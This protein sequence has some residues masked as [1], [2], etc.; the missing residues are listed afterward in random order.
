V[1]KSNR[2]NSARENVLQIILDNMDQGIL[3]VD[4]K[5]RVVMFN[6]RLL[7]LFDYMVEDIAEDMP[8][9]EVLRRWVARG[10]HDEATMRQTIEQAHSREP[11]SIEIP[12]PDGRW[13]EIRHTP[14]PEGGLVRTFT[15][16]TERKRAQERLLHLAHHDPLTDLPN[17]TLFHDRL[18]HAI[19]VATRAEDCLAILYLDLDG[20]KA[21]NDR[22]GHQSGDLLLQSIAKRLRGSVRKSDTVSRIGGDE[23]IVLLAGACSDSSAA[24]V[25]G[26]IL[27]SFER[28][29]KAGG[30][31]I[32]IGVSLG[33][34]RF[35][36]DGADV[37]TLVR[38]AD[39]AM[40]KAKA[41]GGGCWRFYSDPL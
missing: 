31:K 11:L 13:V 36:A 17:R 38:C 27:K 6:R 41:D 9:E 28:P 7:E 30:E 19:E 15:D 25:A 21:I 37:H 1:K 34:A 3:L 33:I 10:G 16:I 18:E 20:F 26:K 32:S 14:L 22:M 29:F 39:S 40:Y 2:R 35:P 8:F 23:F 4:E 5:M 12:L 24:A